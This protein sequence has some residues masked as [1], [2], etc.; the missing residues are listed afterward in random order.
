MKRSA[1]D[2][3]K[4]WLSFAKTPTST[5]LRKLLVLSVCREPVV[6]RAPQLIEGAKR[7]L[8]RGPVEYLVRRTFFDTFCTGEA[9]ADAR[10]CVRKLFEDHHVR[11]ILD[12]AAE[13]DVPDARGHVA[14]SRQYAYQGEAECDRRVGEFETSIRAAGA[15]GFAAVKLTAL[16]DP[17]ILRRVSRCF[18]ETRELFTRLSGGKPS[19]SRDEF[20]RGYDAVFADGNAPALF[21]SIMEQD[22]YRRRWDKLREG[23]AL[24]IITWTTSMRPRQVAAL[25]RASR[26]GADAFSAS[27]LS[28]EENDLQRIDT[29]VRRM[30]HLAW[31]AKEEGARL[32]IDAEQSYFNPVIEAVTLDLQRSLNDA[33]ATGAVVFSTYQAYRRDAAARLAADLERADREGWR[34]ACK[35]VRGAYMN[36]ENALAKQA[37]APSPI[38][39]G[40][41]ATARNYVDCAKLLLSRAPEVEV[42]LATHNQ[43]TIEV[44]LPHLDQVAAKFPDW[45]AANVSFAQ[46]YGMS[47]NLTFSLSRAGFP[48]YKYAPF[49]SVG[50]VIPY[51]V[52][53]AQENS[54]VSQNARDERDTIARELWRRLTGTNPALAAAPGAEAAA[55]TA[56]AGSGVVS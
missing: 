43:R 25:A 11:G 38:Q 14:L 9:E 15:G 10:A 40:V 6:A 16:G 19:I 32:M 51:L 56:A 49:G 20:Q 54:S 48:A 47:D 7:V 30:E 44:L 33:G 37:G 39:P 45:V 55:A 34:F 12:F 23:D 31:Q 5:M 1:V 13:Q 4:P 42:V 35:L 50:D 2:F 21:D 22:N 52:R 29:C 41:E 46:L 27:S 17:D 8:G 24:D 28:L 36:A 53:R 26:A 18:V 3:S